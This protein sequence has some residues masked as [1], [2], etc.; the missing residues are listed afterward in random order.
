M[1]SR[2]P[3]LSW[4]ALR[5]LEDR[6]LLVYCECSVVRPLNPAA[7]AVD[8]R[9]LISHALV[10][11]LASHETAYNDSSG[12]FLFLVCSLQMNNL[13]V[14]AQKTEMTKRKCSCDTEGLRWAFNSTELLCYKER[15]YIPPEASVWAELLKHHHDDELTRHFSIEQTLELVSHKYYWLKLVKDVKKYVFSCDIC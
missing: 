1:R 13:F 10:S 6:Q 8:C 12:F 14:Q 2:K 4:H 3:Q 5:G 9:Q 7:E 11:E 15:L